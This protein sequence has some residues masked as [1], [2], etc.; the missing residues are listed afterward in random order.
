MKINGSIIPYLL[1]VTFSSGQF[2]NLD[3]AKLATINITPYDGAAIPLY[4]AYDDTKHTYQEMKAS[5]EQIKIRSKKH[6]WPWIFI[7]RLVGYLPADCNYK[8]TSPSEKEYFKKI[9]GADIYN[10]TGALDDFYENY[11]LALK[12]SK[13]IGTPGIVIDLEAYNIKSADRHSLKKISNLLGR[14]EN[15][16]INKLQQIGYQLSDI[17]DNEY[18]NATIWFLFTGIGSEV[19]QFSHEQRWVTYMA[20]AMLARARERKMKLKFVTGGELSLGYCYESLQ[21]LYSVIEKRS[22]KMKPILSSHANLYLG[23]TLSPWVMKAEKKSW[24]TKGKCGRSSINNAS[25][26]LPIILELMK[27]YN[28]IWI[29]AS[30]SGGYNPFVAG[31]EH[32]INSVL[33]KTKKQFILIEEK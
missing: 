19:S 6:I 14:K 17:A 32:E 12:I 25:D 21:D 7:N 11:R 20:E 8:I 23:G 13:E 29:Y 15:D 2:A 22:I 28:Y 24:M 5:I 26:F 30:E 16:V 33:E 10:L 3:M 18:P 4:N 27:A 31:K 9:Q 1:L